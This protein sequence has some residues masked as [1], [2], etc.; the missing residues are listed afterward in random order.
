MNHEQIK[1]LIQQAERSLQE[2]RDNVQ[3][4]KDPDLARVDSLIRE[5]CELV[6]SLPREEIAQYEEIL[7]NISRTLKDVSEE[8]MKKRDEL[9]AK[10]QALGTQ[11]HAHTAYARGNYDSDSGD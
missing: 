8:I 11:Q 3:Q 6:S 9:T 1:Y 10:I 5:L 7:Q 4:E 2:C